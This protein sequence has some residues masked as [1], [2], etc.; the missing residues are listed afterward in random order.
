MNSYRLSIERMIEKI[1]SKIL[2]YDR[3][4]FALDQQQ[5]QAQ[6]TLVEL[7][8]LK[9]LGRQPLS[10]QEIAQRFDLKRDL[11]S[12]SVE[13]LDRMGLAE[14]VVSSEDQRVKRI[15]LS[16]AGVKALVSWSDHEKAYLD[17][18]LEEMTVNEQKAVLKFLSRVNQLTVEKYDLQV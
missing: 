18:V 7:W 13:R 5:R 14:K 9:E 16:K 15:G 4:S 12:R 6:V 8:L 17:Y 3:M 1:M 10:I 2:R 11:V